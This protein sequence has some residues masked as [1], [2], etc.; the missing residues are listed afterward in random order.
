MKYDLGSTMAGKCI[1]IYKTGCNC[2][3]M[4]IS[5]LNIEEKIQE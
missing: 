4:E 3:I 5:A 2:R 1:I